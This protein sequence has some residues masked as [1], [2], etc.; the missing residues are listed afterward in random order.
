MIHLLETDACEVWMFLQ[1][2]MVGPVAQSRFK[3]P[4]FLQL[5]HE[6]QLR[7]HAATTG[8]AKIQ[9]HQLNYY[10]IVTH[11]TS[12]YIGLIVCI[13]MHRSWPALR[14]WS[15]GGLRRWISLCCMKSGA[16]ILWCAGV[17]MHM[18]IYMCILS[19]QL[20]PEYDWSAFI[21]TVPGGSW[22]RKWWI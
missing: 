19:G 15:Y 7:V 3:L 8:V 10:I 6:P 4:E 22:H 14:Y 11:A 18:F 1:L 17:Q 12:C 13:L 21:E 2:G 5:R 9:E 20:I 16:L